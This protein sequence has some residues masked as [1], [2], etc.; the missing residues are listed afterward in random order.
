MEH[1]TQNVFAARLLSSIQHTISLIY[2]LWHF[3]NFTST[4]WATECRIQI[5]MGET[6]QKILMSQKT[7]CCVYII[8]P[9]ESRYT[10]ALAAFNIII[11]FLFVFSRRMLFTFRHLYS[12]VYF[13]VFECSSAWCSVH[14]SSLALSIESKWLLLHELRCHRAFNFIKLIV[15]L[16]I[17]L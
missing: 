14:R 16:F 12:F 7:T 17:Y 13:N 2:I 8:R 9:T 15:W 4:N 3:E 6:E 5:W 11:F 10:H 1:G